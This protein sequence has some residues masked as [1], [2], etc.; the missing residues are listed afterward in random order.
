MWISN[1]IREVSN[2]SDP[3][4]NPASE[5]CEGLQNRNPG[6]HGHQVTVEWSGPIACLS[7]G[8]AQSLG[9]NEK[10]IPKGD[11]VG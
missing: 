3:T 8:G 2:I 4:S 11:R 6:N 9:V 1:K 10:G 7:V 5:G